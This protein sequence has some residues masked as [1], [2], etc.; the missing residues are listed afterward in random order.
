MTRLTT[1]RRARRGFTLPELM[2][3]VLAA[4]I[5][6]AVT[7]GGVRGLIRDTRQQIGYNTVATSVEAARGYATKG[8]DLARDLVTSPGANAP[9]FSGAAAIFTPMGEIRLVEN[10]QLAEDGNGAKLETKNDPLNGYKD[11]DRNND[12]IRDVDYILLPKDVGVAGIASERQA[13]TDLAT[14]HAPPFAIR[15]DQKGQLIAGEGQGGNPGLRQRLVYYDGDC[16]GRFQVGRDRN[17]PYSGGTPYNAN[18]W[19]PSSSESPQPLDDTS[20]QPGFHPVMN[21]YKLPFE[22]LEAAIGV[23]VFSKKAFWDTGIAWGDGDHAALHE[24]LLKNGRVMLFN[25]YN[26]EV[27][28]Q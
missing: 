12:G 19:D 20:E 10:D 21:R 6:M 26:G 27:I 11:I 2:V 25:R 24:W 23:V 14:F 28:Q 7:V 22:E 4:G 15:F 8:K 5:L 16:D 13:T 17:D 1:T 3:A 18:V 9:S